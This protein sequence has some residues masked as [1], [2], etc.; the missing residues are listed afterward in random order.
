[1]Y[2]FTRYLL[3][4]LIIGLFGSSLTVFA[5]PSP[6]NDSNQQAALSVVARINDERLAAGLSPL[7]I[8]PTLEAMAKSQVEYLSGLNPMPSGGDLHLGARGENPRERAISAPFNWPYYGNVQQILIGEIAG[9]GGVPFVMSFWL[10][11][12]T[13]RNTMLNPAYRE[14]GIWAAPHRFGYLFIVVFGGRPNELPILF[15]PIEQTLYIPSETYRAG[16]GSI[17]RQ[18]KT[19]QFFTLDQQALTESLPYQPVFKP[20]QNAGEQFLAL[21]S[22]GSTMAISRI[23]LKADM[24]ILSS[25]LPLLTGEATP[26]AQATLTPTP[27]PSPTATLSP[28][29]TPSPTAIVASPTFEA[30]LTPSPS[31]TASPSPSI[32]PTLNLTPSVTPTSALA[33]AQVQIV[34]DARSLTIINNASVPIDISGLALSGQSRNLSAS[35]LGQF[36]PFSLDRFPVGH[37]LQV[38]GFN[39]TAVLNVPSAC[40]QRAS[41]I[42]INPERFFWTQGDFTVTVGGLTVTTCRVGGEVCWVVLPEG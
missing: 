39:E 34:Y 26:I 14:I 2:R 12:Q 27:S 29:V 33:L 1:M 19:V 32:T 41:Y 40:R 35:A 28:S 37:C 13:H 25:T 6:Q 10:G 30:T 7:K 22:D 4:L 31:P 9:I 38:W 21:L 23:D 8:N 11:S 5:K 18:V 20:P 3:L 24:V 15:N 17:I 36:S 16:S 42:T